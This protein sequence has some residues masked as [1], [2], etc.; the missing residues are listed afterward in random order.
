VVVNKFS[1]GRWKIVVLLLT[2]YV[3]AGALSQQVRSIPT[4]LPEHPGNIFLDHE[5]MTLSIPVETSGKLRWQV[6]DD[7]AEI[8]KEGVVNQGQAT[9]KQL[10]IGRLGIG[11]YR[12]E[13]LNERGDLLSWTTAAVLAGLSAPIPEDSPVCVDAAISWYPERKPG[14]REKIAN[15]AALAGVN[16]IRDRLRWRE[17]QP[18]P[19]VFASDTT[20]D[21]LAAYQSNLGMK[22]LQV[23]HGSPD[24]AIKDGYG[25]IPEDLR[26]VYKFCKRLSEKFK[27]EVSAWEPWNE[28]NAV[29]FG[30]LTIDE[31]CSFQ[32]AAYLGFK[33]GNEKAMVGWQPL[34]GINVSSLTDGIMANETWPYYDTYN[35]HSYDWP[36]AYHSL[37]QP[38]RNAACGKPIWVTECDR[39]MKADPKS[40]MGDLSRDDDLRKAEFIAQSYACSLYAGSVRHFHFI[41]GHYMEQ[42]ETVQFGLLRRDLTPRPDYV[43]LAA[44]GRLLA[45][46]NVLGRWEIE[47][48]PDTFVFAFRGFP[49]GVK[50][51][52]LVAWTEVKGD[53]NQRGKTS[54]QW[55][56]PE[57]IHVEGVFDYLGRY[58]G[59][60]SSTFLTSS[61]VIILLPVGE[62]DRLVLSHCTLPVMREGNPS[63]V[64]LQLLM[65]QEQ[66]QTTR[67][68]WTEVNDRVL[69][70]SRE[71][72]LRIIAYNFSS[73]IVV[74]E[75]K[76][77][78]ASEGLVIE[79]GPWKVTL[80]PMERK[81]TEIFLKVL[82][83]GNPDKRGLWI[84]LRGEF[85]EAGRPCLAI[86]G[87]TQ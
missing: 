40:T 31:M 53:W 44:V 82:E 54:V 38:A 16:W 86:R 46:A 5:D 32:K 43:A 33:A 28:G 19:D 3:Q 63:P 66:R 15:L 2:L 34:G 56:L 12:I 79:K 49:N 50:H 24:W 21:Q 81:E 61:P 68:G 42:N 48:Q 57:G 59:T 17:I 85:G 73:K 1:Q 67:E 41:L 87:I 6:L 30:G 60:E 75:I 37:W 51:D 70:S 29:N 20:Y 80:E 14:E 7:H 10:E 74:G 11:W 72:N 26:L 71:N 36:E 78:S 18:F 62:A 58:R 4:P 8:V 9:E 65:P 35:I 83:K 55:C 22:V 77:E 27:G 23:F 13:Y 25:A 39:G 45:G 84:R 64:V 69:S 52:V 47:G 76:V